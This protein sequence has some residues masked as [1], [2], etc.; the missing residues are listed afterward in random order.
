MRFSGSRFKGS[1]VIRKEK[2]QNM[3]PGEA[4]SRRSQ[5]ESRRQEDKEKTRKKKPLNQFYLT[6]NREPLNDV[7]KPLYLEFINEN[8]QNN[9]HGARSKQ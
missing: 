4:G 9:L 8:I 5:V 3:Q 6:V 2:P 7:F 1:G